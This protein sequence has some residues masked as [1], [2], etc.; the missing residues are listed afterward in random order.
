[1]HL[2]IFHTAQNHF[3]FLG[4]FAKCVKF[5]PAKTKSGLALRFCPVGSHVTEMQLIT[6]DLGKTNMTGRCDHFLICKMHLLTELIF[7]ILE[8][9]EHA[10]LDDHDN[11]DGQN[12]TCQNWI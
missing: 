10:V 9:L 12:W 8:S 11:F 1:M 5:C 2:V 4:Q 7:S 3:D 6:F